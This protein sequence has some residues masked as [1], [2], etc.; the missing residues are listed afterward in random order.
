MASVA[1]VQPSFSF[2][3][4]SLLKIYVFARGFTSQKGSAHVLRN[5]L[6]LGTIRYSSLSTTLSCG[7]YICNFYNHEIN[8]TIC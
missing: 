5:A 8:Y 2:S 3:V 6:L 1:A 4:P 7:K